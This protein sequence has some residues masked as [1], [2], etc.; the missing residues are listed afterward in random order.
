MHKTH[1][2][3]TYGLE[4]SSEISIPGLPE[5]RNNKSDVSIC[6]GTP[7]ESLKGERRIGR[8]YEVQRKKLLI[9][10]EKIARILVS[11]GNYILI[12][13]LPGS[14][15]HQL[16]LLLMGWGLGALLQQRNTPALHGSVICDGD[17]GFVICAPSGVGKSTLTV[18]F[19]QRGYRYLDDNIA[20]FSTSNKTPI[21]Y[22]GIPHI[23]LW[24]DTMEIFKI[25][26]SETK[27]L[28]PHVQ[29]FQITFEDQFC[30]HPIQVRAIYILRRSK[31]KTL[32]RKEIRGHKTLNILIAQVFCH[33]FL[34]NIYQNKPLLSSIIN[35]ANQTKVILIDLPETL[36]EP[37]ELADYIEQDFNYQIKEKKR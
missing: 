24:Q 20:V 11:N 27:P 8:K 10:T 29:K 22:P 30:H 16:R 6:Y 32:V 36:C 33:Q 1:S 37:N 21:V 2:Y 31:Q 13:P 25:E 19:L 12:K 3:Y 23:K 4:I 15:E 28:F 17:Q 14:Q 34:L 18:A 35:I 7:P 5:G 9:K 26:R